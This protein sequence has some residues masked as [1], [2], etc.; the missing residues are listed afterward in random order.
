L[1]RDR[2][3]STGPKSLYFATPLGLTSQTEGFPWDDLRKIFRDVNGWP[4][5]QMP[6]KYCRKFEPPE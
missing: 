6:Q 2:D 3:P 1:H 5:Y 4:M